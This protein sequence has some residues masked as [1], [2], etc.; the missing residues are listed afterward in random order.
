MFI[1]SDR[2][3]LA[4]ARQLEERWAF[5]QQMENGGELHA[6][7]IVFSIVSSNAIRQSP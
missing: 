4:R 3:E 2:I 5:Q 6:S 1:H 7:S